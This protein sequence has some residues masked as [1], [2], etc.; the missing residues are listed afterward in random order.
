MGRPLRIIPG[1][2]AYH[3]INRANAHVQIFA[4]NKDYLC[5]E[6]ILADACEKFSMRLCTYCIMP[7]HW[8]LVLWPE[9]DDELSKFVGWFT[10][11]HTQ[12]WHANHNTTGSG[13]L[14]QGRFKSFPVQ[15]DSHFLTLCRYVERNPVSAGLV[16]KSKD[17]RWSAMWHRMNRSNNTVPLSRWPVDR[18]E[19]WQ[20]LVDQ[21]LNERE[22]ADVRKCIERNRPFGETDWML[23]TAFSLGLNSALKTRGRPRKHEKG[24]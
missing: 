7:N 24:S 12:R 13:H 19:N 1:G 4:E 16:E 10:L 8:H 11:T 20:H 3:V 15:D 22:A 17:W 9:K 5:F 18:P 21:E 6:N 14:Y 2:Y 23:K